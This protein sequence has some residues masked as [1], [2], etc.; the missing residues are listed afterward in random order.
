MVLGGLAQLIGIH[1]GPASQV[2]DFI[3]ASVLVMPAMYILFA[4]G[5]THIFRMVYSHRHMLRWACLA[6]IVF[7]MLPSAN[8]RPG[9]HILYD[10]S[11]VFMDDSD[12][13]LRVQQLQTRRN[14]IK[15]FKLIANW[16]NHNT[17]SSVIVLSDDI[18]MRM[19]CRRPILA[20]RDDLQYT[21]H[22]PADSF[23][24]WAQRLTRQDELIYT[25]SRRPDSEAIV[26]W[27]K[28]IELQNKPARWLM[29][30]PADFCPTATPQL[31][32]VHPEGWGRHFK[33]YIINLQ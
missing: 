33:L 2:I 31:E 29:P 20:S 8:F 25:S 5:L 19:Y 4:Q 18:E 17:D 1:K 22:L 28:T 11:T 16:I 9:R 7:W 30:L 24:Q 13:P 3:Q 21:R 32:E 6:M 10:T 15:E 12:K 27:L 26:E 23:E 14:K